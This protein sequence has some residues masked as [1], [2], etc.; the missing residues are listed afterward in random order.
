MVLKNIMMSSAQNHCWIK[1]N[2]VERCLEMMLNAD[3]SAELFL[4]VCVC[5]CVFQGPVG[6]TGS[7]GFPGLRVSRKHTHTHTHT[8]S[9]I[10]VYFLRLTQNPRPLWSRADMTSHITN[11]R[12]F[13]MENKSNKITSGKQISP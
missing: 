2:Q 5:V 10:S 12:S 11:N 13:T 7:S 9:L 8:Q 6:G 1:A 3:R 4:M